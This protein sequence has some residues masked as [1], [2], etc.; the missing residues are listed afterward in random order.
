MMSRKLAGIT[1]QRALKVKQY[2]D[3]LKY[4]NNILI[5]RFQKTCFG[6]FEKVKVYSRREKDGN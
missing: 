4:A 6:K 2:W 3:V 1:I 5:C